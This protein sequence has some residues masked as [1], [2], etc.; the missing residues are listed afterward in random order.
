MQAYRKLTEELKAL[1]LGV[2]GSF[3][4]G[5]HDAG[6]RGSIPVGATMFS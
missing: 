5:C 4:R 3:A 2:V 6:I 1:E